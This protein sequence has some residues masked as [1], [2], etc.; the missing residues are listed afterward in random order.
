LPRKTKYEEAIKT[1]GKRNSYSKTDKDATFMR[2][3]ED[4]MGNGQ[5][6]PAYNVQIGT[7]N[8]FVVG[9]DIFPNPTDTRTLKP[10]LKKQAKRLGVKPKMVI[11][12]AGYGSEENYAYLE[13]RRTIAV[14]P[15]NMYRKEQTKKWKTDQFKIENWEYHRC[16]KYYICPNGKRVTYRET[17]EKKTESGYP[18]SIDRYECESCED[19]PMKES[20]T[21]AKGNRSVQRNERLISLK[22]KAVRI[23]TDERYIPIRKQRSVEVE[24]VF[25]QIKGNQGFRRFLLRGTEKVSTEW[26]L[27]ALG[28]NMKQLFRMKQAKTVS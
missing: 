23:L 10:H 6:K 19:C 21:Q 3:K 18:T 17:I 24:T 25:G 12:D 16:E 1:C 8:G 15:Y 14:I 4:H 2:M 11:T 27:L 9:Y 28:Y 22:K 13:N 5:L 20:C 26:G 7:E